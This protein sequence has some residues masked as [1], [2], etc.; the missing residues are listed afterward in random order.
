MLLAAV[1]PAWIARNRVQGA[2][3]ALAGGAPAI[4]MDDGF[5]NPGLAK[6]LSLLVI[7]GDYGLGNGRCIPLVPY[8]KHLLT[9]WQGPTV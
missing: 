5:Q 6:D 1:A 7:D 3:A 2:R 9:V 8:A 4:V